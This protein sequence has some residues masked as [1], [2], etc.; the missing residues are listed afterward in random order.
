[1]KTSSLTT[2]DNIE[3]RYGYAVSDLRKPWIVLVIPF[4]LDVAIATPF[5]DFFKTHYNVCTWE[6]RSVLENSDRACGAAEFSIDQHVADL[7]AVIDTLKIKEAILVGYCSGAGVALAA[8]N[9]EP[10]RFSQL[11]LAHGEYTMLGEKDCVTQFAADMDVLLTLA[12]SSDER[13][14]LVFEKIQSERY[15]AN[16]P[17]PAGLDQPFGDV[18]YLKRYASNYLAYKATDYQQLAAE[19]FH[20]T[21]LM[22]GGR[23]VQVNVASSEKIRGHIRNS[24]IFVDPDADHYGVLTPDSGTLIA[25]WNHILEN[26]HARE[27][28]SHYS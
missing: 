25:I 28:H 23:D 27:F 4:G 11:V 1:M 22:A 2:S 7:I 3:L 13:A 24:S 14:Q 10:N 20:P 19:V 9:Q 18:R 16:L 26:S 5:F 21:L 6:S 17:R 15:D 8:I 12:A